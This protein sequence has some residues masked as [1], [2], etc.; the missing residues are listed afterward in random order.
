MFNETIKDMNLI[1]TRML[2]C[3]YACVSV[4]VCKSEYIK[5]LNYKIL[6]QALEIIFIIFMLEAK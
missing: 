1:F 4:F 3:V 2:L 5:I 6:I